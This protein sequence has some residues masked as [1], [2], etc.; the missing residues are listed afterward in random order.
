[1]IKKISIFLLV[2]I[3]LIAVLSLIFFYPF[4][5]QVPEPQEAKIYRE[6]GFKEQM[7]IYSTTPN[8]DQINFILYDIKAYKLHN[9]PFSKNTPKIE[10][11][12]GNGVFNSEIIMNKIETSEG[13]IDEEDI[14]IIISEE[15]FLNTINSNPKTYL[16]DSISQGKT[17]IE[18]SAGNLE[19]AAKGYL[20]LHKEINGESL[21]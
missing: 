3:F 14:R 18:L 12:I 16:Q 20:S 6:Q 19:L 4:L 13:E 7:Q 1:M 10:F 2:L 21:N 17:K 5:R 8:I 9:P 15:E 11:V